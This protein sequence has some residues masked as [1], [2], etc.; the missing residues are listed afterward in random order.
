MPEDGR[1]GSGAQRPCAGFAAALA[2]ARPHP[3]GVP[4]IRATDFWSFAYDA[5]VPELELL[6]PDHGPALL[7]FE[8]EN[9]AYFAASIPDRGD[10][11]FAHFD[12][13][14][15][16]L[17]AGQEAGLDYFHV[18]VG[19]GGEVLGR[20]NLIEVTDGTAE[21]GYR[22]AEKAAGRG[23]A[24]RAVRQVL[25]LAA[26]AYGLRTVRAETTEDNGASRAVL[27]RVGFVPTGGIVL[28]GRPGIRYALQLPP[29]PPAPDPQ[30]GG[31]SPQ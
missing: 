14:H 9:R 13:R 19:A 28:D 5:A 26:S 3:G 27:T 23:L 25:D 2:G 16:A 15:A 8:R 10:E 12:E 30:L 4:E 24:T 22:I 6:R 20:V 1:S 17:L 29:A 7:A 31:N 18:L 11:Y 21:L